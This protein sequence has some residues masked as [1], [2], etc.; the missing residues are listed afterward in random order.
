M[1]VDTVAMSTDRLADCWVFE[2]L[3]LYKTGCYQAAMSTVDV[4]AKDSGH[5]F[6]VSRHAAMANGKVNVAITDQ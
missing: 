1:M 4:D 2:V 3:S 6:D 5:R